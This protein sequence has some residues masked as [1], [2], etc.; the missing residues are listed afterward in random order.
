MTEQTKKVKGL[1]KRDIDGIDLVVSPDLLIDTID[2][3]KELA[4]ECNFSTDKLEL[5]TGF[6]DGTKK[7]KEDAA[8]D[9]FKFT[10]DLSKLFYK[11]YDKKNKTVGPEL[12]AVI[13]LLVEATDLSYDVL[14]KSDFRFLIELFKRLIIEPQGAINE[15]FL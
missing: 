8:K 11:E 7:E 14:V 10:I 6:K 1:S 5:A 12:K 9:L 3:L 2:K 13:N 15:G 4:K